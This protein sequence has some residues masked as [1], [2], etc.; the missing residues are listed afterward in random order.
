MSMTWRNTAPTPA[1]LNGSPE[2][3][4]WIRGGCFNRPLL[5]RANN[6]TTSDLVN[7]QRVFRP[8]C[9]F[10]FY[11]DGYPNPIWASELGNWPWLLR[12]EWAGPIERVA[13]VA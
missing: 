3:Y 7:G 9:N 2:E 13:D 4:F 12:L 5:V 1:D 6:G 8:E 10:E 11:A